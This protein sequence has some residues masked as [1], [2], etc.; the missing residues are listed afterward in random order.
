MLSGPLG[1]VLI[2]SQLGGV[3]CYNNSTAMHTAYKVIT[4]SNVALLA[5]SSSCAGVKPKSLSRELKAPLSGAR[6]VH[7]DLLV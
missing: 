5:G 6:M 3:I 7:V 4:L 1:K 2:S